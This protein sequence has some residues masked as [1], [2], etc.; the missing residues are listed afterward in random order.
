MIRTEQSNRRSSE[1]L[2]LPEPAVARFGI[3]GVVLIDISSNGAR[4]EHSIALERGTERTLRIRW[5]DT[6]LPIE[7]KVVSSFIH[8]FRG[9]DDGATI[10][11]SGL[12]FHFSKESDREPLKRMI[13][14]FVAA[15][16]VEQVANARGFLPPAE[17]DMPIFRFGVLT[18]NRLEIRKE[19]RDERAL[20]ASTIVQEQGFITFFL[21]RGKW[22]RKW[23]SRP[24]QPDDGFTV[25]AREPHAQID[26]L[27]HQY[28]T[29]DR[30]G[31]S[32]IRKLAELS[33]EA[34][35]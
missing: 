1:R 15:T 10:F 17:H 30:D 20:A 26:L 2:A 28:K 14:A 5:R 33:V 22:S 25:S 31:R 13:S 35:V 3:H 24:E 29:S 6:D 11:R 32:L 7:A 23:T 27:C 4:V 16:L 18:R 21:N 19:R 34:A 8:R 12:Q 9:G